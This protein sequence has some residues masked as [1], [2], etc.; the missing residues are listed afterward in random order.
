MRKQMW[1]VLL[2]AAIFAL[3]FGVYS[4]TVRADGGSNFSPGDGRT[5]P[6]TTDRIAVYVSDTGAVVWGLDDHN[7]GFPLTSFSVDEFNSGKTISHKTAQGTVTLHFISP[8]T[9]HTG[10]KDN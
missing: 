8:A 2:L 1:K 3:L 5:N 10:F 4:V 6:N 7:V 9:W